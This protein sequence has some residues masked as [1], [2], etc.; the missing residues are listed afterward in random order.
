MPAATPTPE[1]AGTSRSGP[2]CQPDLLSPHSA[3]PRI[4]ARF[5]RYPGH[6]PVGRGGGF[7]WVKQQGYAWFTSRVYGADPGRVYDVKDLRLLLA[8]GLNRAENPLVDWLLAESPTEVVLIAMSQSD[9]PLDYR[10]DLEWEKLGIDR[11]QTGRFRVAG[12]D[13]WRA[14]SAGD[15]GITIPPKGLAVFR[16]PRG[17]PKFQRPNS[18]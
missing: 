5:S 7:P 15:S 2:G 9:Q 8:R 1:R 6:H 10:P 13:S 18:R 17:R 11:A 16:F 14:L 4:H 3:A 12:E